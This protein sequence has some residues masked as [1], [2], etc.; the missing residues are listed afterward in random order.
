MSMLNNLRYL[1]VSLLR[2]IYVRKF[3]HKSVF[4]L[5]FRLRIYYV[6]DYVIITQNC[7]L[8]SSLNSKDFL[9]HIFEKEDLIEGSK[10]IWQFWDQ[11]WVLN[12]FTKSMEIGHYT[13]CAFNFAILLKDPHFLV[14]L[15]TRQLLPT[16]SLQ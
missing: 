10:V 5:A 6:N 14:C 12:T 1:N 3:T 15:T 11:W 4:I 9:D 8:G 16:F 7:W 2:N 13:M